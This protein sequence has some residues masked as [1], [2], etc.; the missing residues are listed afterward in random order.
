VI[1]IG[2]DRPAESEKLGESRVRAFLVPSDANDEVIRR[3][4]LVHLHG[5]VDGAAG[6]TGWMN[7]E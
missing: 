5:A 3:W 1:A 2:V 6:K 7:L 4:D